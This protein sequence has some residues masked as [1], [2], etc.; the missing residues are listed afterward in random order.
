MIEDGIDFIEIVDL[1]TNDRDGDAARVDASKIRCQELRPGKSHDER[2]PAL[3]FDYL[4]PR[5]HGASATVQLAI[6]QRCLGNAV[7]PQRNVTEAS[8]PL[9]DPVL[10]HF[11]ESLRR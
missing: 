11:R 5:R 1:R 3:R 2:P 9:G 6:G 7:G 10:N 8:R 4:K